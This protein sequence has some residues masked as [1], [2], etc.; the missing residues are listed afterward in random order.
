[1]EEFTPCSVCSRMPLVGEEVTVMRKGKTESLVCDP[2]LDRPRTAAL[3]DAM[4]RERVK[5]AAGG[6]SVR[7]VWPQP[8]KEPV[9]PAVVG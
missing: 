7:R 8:A 2:C 9:D 3:G 5:T 1:M 4:R 6:S